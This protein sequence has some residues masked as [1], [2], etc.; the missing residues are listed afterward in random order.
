M[1]MQRAVPADGPDDW[2]DE[3]AERPGFGARLFQRQLD[4]YPANGPRTLYLGVTVLATII[5]YYQLYIPGA[6]ATQL[7]DAFDMQL[8]YFIIISVVGNAI[9][10]LGS[11]AAGLADRTAA[12]TTAMNHGLL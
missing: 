11:L 1:T 4:H 5:L 10:A 3:P 8:R 6:V 2:S 7:L 9:G 12:V